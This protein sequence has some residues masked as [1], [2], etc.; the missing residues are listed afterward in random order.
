MK[1]YLNVLKHFQQLESASGIVLF[2]AAG[3]AMFWA[4]SPWV[5]SYVQLSQK[6]FW[7]NEGLM[8]LFFFLVGLELKREIVEGELRSPAAVILPLIA[9]FG[10]MVVPML[11]YAFFNDNA[12]WPIPAATDIA[13]TLG[14]LSLLGKRVPLGLKL[15]LM[16]LAI[17]DDIGAILMIA[18][19]LKSS[20]HPAVI[21]VFLAML[22]PVSMGKIVE[23]KL[24]PWVAYGIMPLFALMN[25][26]FSFNQVNVFNSVTLGIIAGLFLG[27]QIGVLSFSWIAIRTGLARLPSQVS[28]FA[29]WGGSILCGIGFTMSLFLG[30]LAFSNNSFYMTEVRLGVFLGSLLSGIIGCIVLYEQ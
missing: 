16:A 29:L 17:F 24:H 3:L 10:G 27:K 28:W 5:A 1:N 7:V 14:A 11:I 18:F 15:F 23:E 22:V 9:A 8:P 4:N 13:F 19:F 30:T 26:G 25:A 21:G 2:L 6:S 20:I 12:G